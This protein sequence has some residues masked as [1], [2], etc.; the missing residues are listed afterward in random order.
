[1]A[2]Q[3]G[4]F[5]AGEE[6]DE[7]YFLLDNGA[8]DDDVDFNAE[9]NALV[10]EV[11]AD[12]NDSMFRCNQCEKIC[13]SQQGLT[14]HKNAKHPAEPNKAKQSSSIS[15]KDEASLRK[16]PI[17]RLVSILKEC[18]R[19]V[20]SDEC[21]PEE[22]RKLF[23]DFTISFQEANELWEK[24]R[25]VIDSSCNDLEKFYSKFYGLFSENLL[26]NKFEYH[27][28]NILMAEAAKHIY[29]YLEGIDVKGTTK[30]SCEP[31]VVTDKEIKCLQYVSGYIVHKLYRKYR[32]SRKN[33]SDNF[34]TQC[35]AILQACKIDS[36]DSQTLVNV[37]DRGGLWR[38]NKNM[39]ALFLKC[40]QLFR[41]HTVKFS[42]AV[43]CKNIVNDMLQNSV[44]KSNYK[45]VCYD[46]DPKVDTEISMNL[47]EQILTLFVRTRTFSYAKDIR[48]KHKAAKKAS[49]Q[50]SL[51][52]ELKKASS[53]TDDGGH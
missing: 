27:I 34:H 3:D 33:A 40:E 52:T 44:I 21:L 1:M 45:N 43:V 31:P 12:P 46:V 18:A 51:R 13:K 8:L 20:V 28:T 25:P 15:D 17:A 7:L 35:V 10:N 38:V 39:Q 50:R 11:T 24:L 47:L 14:R 4:D 6:L 29:I 37:R 42:V 30:S 53:T 26:P 2:Q 22:T 48:E 19:I 32:F 23:S 5:L 16:F 41:S 36:D 9:L 49:R